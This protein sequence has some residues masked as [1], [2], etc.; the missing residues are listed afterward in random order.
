MGNCPKCGIEVKPGQNFCTRCGASLQVSSR[1]TGDTTPVSISRAAVPG[2]DSRPPEGGRPETS[3]HSPGQEGADGRPTGGAGRE[4]EVLVIDRSGSTSEPGWKGTKLHD[5]KGATRS[6]ILQ[7]RHMDRED[8]L[9]FVSFADGARTECDWTRLNNP[10]PLLAAA[11]G[12]TDGGNTCFRAGLEEAEGLLARLP[13][14]SGGAVTKKIL[15]LTDGHNNRGDPQEVAERLRSSGV[16]VQA[17]GFEASRKDVGLDILRQMVS[18]IDGQEQ[19]W[20]CSSLRELTKTF[21]SL[22]R[23]TKQKTSLRP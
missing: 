2:T 22:T 17:I 21:T 18:V 19:Y 23:Q 16:I 10:R 5:I 8:Y 4:V 7:K 1:Y 15:F 11:E 14:E 12:L 13:V 3:L 9:A 20:F 6:Y